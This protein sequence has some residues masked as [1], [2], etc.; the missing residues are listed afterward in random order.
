MNINLFIHEVKHYW[1]DHKKVVLGV[2]AL[3]IILA[4]L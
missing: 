1:N 4:I 2:A 3:I